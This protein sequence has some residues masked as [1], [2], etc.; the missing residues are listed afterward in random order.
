MSCAYTDVL[1]KIEQDVVSRGAC[2]DVETE[3]GIQPHALQICIY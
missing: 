1:Y 3:N 2:R